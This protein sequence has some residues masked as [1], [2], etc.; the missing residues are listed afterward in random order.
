MTTLVNL[1]AT[2]FLLTSCAS[3]GSDYRH[4]KEIDRIAGYEAFLAKHPSSEFDKV[5]RARLQELAVTARLE[6]ERQAKLESEAW[7]AAKTSGAPSNLAGFL[8]AYPDGPHAAQA[9]ALMPSL[10]HDAALKLV[11]G[12]TTSVISDRP[13]PLEIFSADDLLAGLGTFYLIAVILTATESSAEGHPGY[14]ASSLR[15]FCDRIE[16][17]YAG[18]GTLTLLLKIKI[19]Q[20][21]SEVISTIAP[22]SSATFYAYETSD[23][24]LLLIARKYSN[25]TLTREKIAMG[26]DGIGVIRRGAATEAY[27]FPEAPNVIDSIL[28]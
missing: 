13:L 8:R 23:P 19:N 4:A 20:P 27:L 2:A 14:S 12:D 28:R 9:Q 21:V 7:D 26:G 18:E 10:I 22:G 17:Q 11:G 1:F 6:Q 3:T 24:L 15:I 16:K 25:G 5:A